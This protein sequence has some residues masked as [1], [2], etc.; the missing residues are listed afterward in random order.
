MLM[1]NTPPAT[2]FA[3]THGQS[4]FQFF[5]LAI[6]VDA[7]ALSHG[8]GE[9]HIF[10]RGDLYVSK[11]ERDWLLGTLQKL[12]PGCHVGIHPSRQEWRWYVEHQ[13]IGVMVRANPRS[14]LFA[15]SSSPSLDQR[16]NVSFVIG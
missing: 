8:R 12:F 13:Y 9:R 1:H 10:P 5:A 15:N 2:N 6:P 3:E 14:V 4:K 7:R 16:S 11:V